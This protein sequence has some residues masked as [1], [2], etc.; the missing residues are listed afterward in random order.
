[1]RLAALACIVFT[2]FTGVANA[3]TPAAPV[4]AATP[5]KAQKLDIPTIRDRLAAVDDLEA[6]KVLTPEQA[7]AQRTHYLKLAEEANG[8]PMTREQVEGWNSLQRFFTFINFVYVLAGIMLVLALAWIFIIIGLPS[9]V[10]EVLLYAASLGLTFGLKGGIFGIDAI[11][12]VFPACLALGGAVMLSLHLHA[13]KGGKWRHAMTVVSVICCVVWTIAAVYHASHL[14]GFIAAM[15]LVSAL[16]F[17]V[18]V[19]PLCIGL[20]FEEEDAMPRATVAS[21]LMLVA[22]SALHATGLLPFGALKADATE[23]VQ[24]LS[25]FNPGLI[26]VGTFVYFIGL[27]ILSSKWYILSYDYETRGYK[28][29]AKYWALQILTVVS[30]F[31]ALYFGATLNIGLLTGIGGTFF[32]IYLAEKYIEISWNR[33]GP[34]WMLLIGAGLLYALATFAQAHPQYFLLGF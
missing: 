23:L 17:S 5:A 28:G 22:G 9:Q 32:G 13:P 29:Y 4:P 8:A 11:W 10:W 31:A 7:E 20:G 34:A 14:L 18:F 19:G 3:E 6:R 24:H 26:F 30:G 12:I 2:L 27:L 25:V 1:M 33:I 15:A 16:G 21:F